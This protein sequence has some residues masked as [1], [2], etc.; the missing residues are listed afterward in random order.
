MER[1]H[2]PGGASADG[3]GAGYDVSQP[4]LLPPVCQEVSDPL[5]GGGWHRDLVMFG[6]KLREDGVERQAEVHK[7]NPC[8]CPCGVEV[9]QH[10]DVTP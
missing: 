6:L 3:V 5:S 10:V 9:M 7:Q 4:Y 2:V 1:A 8:V